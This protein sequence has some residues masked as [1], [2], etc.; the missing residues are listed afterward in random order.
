MRDVRVQEED[1]RTVAIRRIKKKTDLKAHLF[2]YVV[3]NSMLV[4]IWAIT[5]VGF[6][7]P[8]FPML[9]WGVGIVFNV[10]DVY[11]RDVPTEQEVQREMH[12][13]RERPMPA[14]DVKAEEGEDDD[15][16][17]G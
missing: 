2:V 14:V 11:R 4:T 9:A 15:A 7:W 1:L 12:R 16:T 3:V 8:I 17:R 6:F 10:W 5:G 13:L